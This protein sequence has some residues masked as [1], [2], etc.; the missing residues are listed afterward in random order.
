MTVTVP[1][2]FV[3][4]WRCAVAEGEPDWSKATVAVMAVIPPGPAGRVVAGR[5]TG[6][7]AWLGPADD[8]TA[9]DG[10]AAAVIVAMVVA[11]VGTATEL[12]AVPADGF[13]AELAVVAIGAG[14]TGAATLPVLACLVTAMST[15][16]HPA[17]NSTALNE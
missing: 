3:V 13:G 5:V 2:P 10:V 6:G 8:S 4:M 1:V 7:G 14:L 16:T 17:K 11:V 15:N 9:V 12:D